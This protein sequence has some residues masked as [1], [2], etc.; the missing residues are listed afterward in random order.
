M[1]AYPK[2]EMVE[3]LIFDEINPK[4]QNLKKSQVFG[5]D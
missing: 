4:G 5:N 2:L 1:V 3:V